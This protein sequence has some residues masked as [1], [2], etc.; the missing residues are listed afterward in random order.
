MTVLFVNKASE[1]LVIRVKKKDIRAA[2]ERDKEE[3][4][5]TKFE[6][7]LSLVKTIEPRPPVA[8]EKFDK[9][10]PGSLAVRMLGESFFNVR[11]NP[12]HTVGIHVRNFEGIKKFI[13]QVEDEL[14]PEDEMKDLQVCL[15]EYWQRHP[16]IQEE[17][18]EFQKF[19]HLWC[20]IGDKDAKKRP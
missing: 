11:D 5:H 4:V 20:C 9:E 19:L 14:T 16:P 3:P 2:T 12:S 7:P 15:Q 18:S 13:L 17:S 6:V 8:K 10:P 1:V